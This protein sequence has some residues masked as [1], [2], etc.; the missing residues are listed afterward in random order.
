MRKINIFFNTQSHLHMGYFGWRL[1]TQAI[2]IQHPW[3]ILFPPAMLV[4]ISCMVQPVRWEDMFT[5][6]THPSFWL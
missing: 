6:H 2:F 4:A 5:T 1:S 3:L